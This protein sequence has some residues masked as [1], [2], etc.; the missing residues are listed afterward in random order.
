MTEIYSAL[1]AVWHTRDIEALRSGRGIVPHHVYLIISDLCNQDCVFC[2]YRSPKG[3]GSESFGA[4]TG[5]GFTKN[6]DR[7]I[8]TEKAL[9]ILDDSNP[10][11]AR[12][13]RSSTECLPSRQPRGATAH[14][15]ATAVKLG[16][17]S[18]PT[19]DVSGAR[20]YLR[21]GIGP[22]AYEC[23]GCDCNW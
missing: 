18:A 7:M 2:S 23:F 1:K 9:E 19:Q 21:S 17:F 8:P 16:G 13:L 6:P 5:N 3:W 11:P 15:E 22:G 4:D 10:S 14:G 12:S 20:P